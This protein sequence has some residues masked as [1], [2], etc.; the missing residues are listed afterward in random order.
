MLS[1]P[2]V[3]QWHNITVC[4]THSTHSLCLTF[5]F[6]I[7]LIKP[8]SRSKARQRHTSTTSLTRYNLFRNSSFTTHFLF[9]FSDPSSVSD[10]ILNCIFCL[11]NIFLFTLNGVL[12]SREDNR[13]L[14]LIIRECCFKTFCLNLNIFWILKLIYIIKA[15]IYN[16]NKIGKSVGK[17]MQKTWNYE[18]E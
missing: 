4:V 10:S 15:Y 14:M 17:K 2:A 18:Y 6:L 13:T 11:I 12:Q 9:F 8:L 3:S 1:G 7:L 5:H 16:K